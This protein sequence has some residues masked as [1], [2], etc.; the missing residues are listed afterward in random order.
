MTQFDREEVQAA[1]AARLEIQERDD[2]VAFADTFTG[3]AVYVEHH[4]GTFRGHAAIKEWLVPVMKLCEGWTY[5]NE[6]VVI[7]G[8]R[9][10]Y[11]WWNRLPGKRSDGSYYEFAGISVTEYAGDGKFNFQEDLYNWEET[12]AVMTQ[13]SEDNKAADGA[14]DGD[15]VAR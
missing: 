11:K 4:E 6:W 13:W 14:A 2:W 3:D 8:N 7:E 9:V 10:I 12:M 1:F 5:P 15:D